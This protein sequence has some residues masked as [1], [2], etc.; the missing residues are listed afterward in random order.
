MRLIL[1]RVEVNLTWNTIPRLAGPVNVSGSNV[2]QSR[3]GYVDAQGLI[4]SK[5]SSRERVFVT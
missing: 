1:V 2:C 4:T 3:V 5:A